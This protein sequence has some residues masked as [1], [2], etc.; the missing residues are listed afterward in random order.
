LSRRKRDKNSLL[1]LFFSGADKIR[2]RRLDGPRRALPQARRRFRMRAVGGALVEAFHALMATRSPGWRGFNGA[3]FRMRS[4][5]YHG[6]R[7]GYAA[8]NGAGPVLDEQLEL[9]KR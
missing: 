1:E 6:K 4:L 7:S 9:K 3:S 5:Q 8:T 2:S